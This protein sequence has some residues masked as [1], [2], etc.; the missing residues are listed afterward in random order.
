MQTC[1]NP[2]HRLHRIRG[3]APRALEDVAPDACR[4]VDRIYGNRR[5]RTS[6]RSPSR[7]WVPFAAKKYPRGWGARVSVPLGVQTSRCWSIRSQIHWQFIGLCLPAVDSRTED[8]RGYKTY[9]S[10]M[11]SSMDRYLCEHIGLVLGP[12]REGATMPNESSREDPPTSTTHKGS[13]TA[14]G[15][16]LQ[17]AIVRSGQQDTQKGP[18][19]GFW[20]A[21]LALVLVSVVAFSA[22]L[23]FRSAFEQA[24]DVTTVLSSLFAVV[25]TVVG[26]YLGIKTSGDTRDAT[27]GAIERAHETANRAL[28][29]LPPEVG[30]R[31][32]G[33][34]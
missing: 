14:V 28:A 15:A 10:P 24:T 31:V 1:Q 2:L 33:G 8:A 3:A 13:S 12:G 34:G 30:R 32:A 19:Y 17:P 5:P 23:I 26:A 27:Q 25:G 21:A 18:A 22:L 29:D 7:W 9:A 4:L 6:K 11:E 16:S 20:L